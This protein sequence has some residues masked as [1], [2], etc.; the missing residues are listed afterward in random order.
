MKLSDARARIDEIDEELVKLFLSRM[1][2]SRNVAEIKINQGLP[3]LNQKR[4]EEI[5]SSVNEKAGE[6]GS[7]ARLFFSAIMDISR[8]YQHELMTASNCPLKGILEG[9]E[10]SFKAD[11][12]L[13]CQGTEGAYSHAAA[14]TFFKAAKPCFYSSFEEVFKAVEEGRADYGVLPVEN[15]LAGS[16]T[17]VYDLILKYKFFITGTAEVEV[18][19]CLLGVKGASK[20]G[21]R[22]VYSHP[23]ALAQCSEFIKAQ[24]LEA[25]PDSNTAVAA[26]RISKLNDTQIGVIAS[27]EAA[28]THGLEV[29]ECDIQ[30]VRDNRTRFILIS[31]NLIIPTNADIISLSFSLPHTTGS[32]YKILGRFAIHGLNLTKIESRPLYGSSFEY[33]F[34][35]DFAGTAKDKDIVQLL[36]SLEE[37]LPFFSFLGNYSEV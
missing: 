34:Y 24:K 4:E 9:A 10:S 11:S 33:Q 17:E 36:C 8:A 5:L 7:A 6:H 23:Q 16:V 22:K 31:K 21:L 2:I 37:E 18:H 3:V 28:E 27:R 20:E 15:N 32:L 19:H 35:L 26:E 14:R 12:V 29:L 25:A 30:N 13:A 1:E